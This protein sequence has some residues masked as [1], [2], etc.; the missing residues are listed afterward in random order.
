ME[1]LSVI[2]P[3]IY[4]YA[5]PDKG[6]SSPLVVDLPH[7]G[8]I[9]PPDF[10][11]SCPRSTLELCEEKYL[12]EFFLAP[13]LAAGGAV[14]Q[15]KFPRTYVDANRAA[16][17]IDQLLFDTPWMEPTATDGRSVHGFGVIMRHIRAGE[18]IYSHPLS[19]DEARSRIENYYSIYHNTLNKLLNQM[20]DKFNVVYHLNCHSMPSSVLSTHFPHLQPDFI[21]GDKDG[22]SCG[23]DFR[24]KIAETLKDMGYRVAINQL[25][26]GAEIITRYG[27]PAW[28]RHSLQIEINR[29]LFQNEATGEKNRNFNQIRWDIQRL[30]S[31]ITVQQ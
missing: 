6:I 19:H 4:E 20:H 10:N 17:D 22:R 11:F 24:Q 5:L 26:K 3:D 31:Q 9:Y 23:L 7:G 2:H 8:D 13:T 25:Y 1:N 30:I 18:P 27:A 29:A 12:G 15:A 14:I 16:N 21:L 28:G